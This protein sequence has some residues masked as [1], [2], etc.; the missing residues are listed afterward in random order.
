MSGQPRRHFTAVFEEQAVARLSEPGASQTSVAR[1]LDV[2]PSQLKGWRPRAR[3]RRAGGS[4]PRPLSWPSCAAR[5][6]A[7][8]KRWR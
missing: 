3:Q 1:E 7:S 5:T 4:K 6:A 2:T 8:G